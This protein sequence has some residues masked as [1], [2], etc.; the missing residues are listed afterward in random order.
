MT[1]NVMRGYFSKLSDEVARQTGPTTELGGKLYGHVRRLPNFVRD[2]SMGGIE[3]LLAQSPEVLGIENERGG[4]LL[5]TPEEAGYAAAAAAMGMPDPA[6][7]EFPGI[8]FSIRTTEDWFAR[9]H[10]P[11]VERSIRLS[12]VRRRVQRLKREREELRAQGKMRPER[13]P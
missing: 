8:T 5:F 11:A 3:R 9:P 10:S 1:D 12:V 2:P 6:S 13:L 4:V 7:P